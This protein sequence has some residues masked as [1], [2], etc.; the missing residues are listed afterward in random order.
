LQ[1]FFIAQET[2]V[3]TLSSSANY[4]DNWGYLWTG[5]AAYS[6]WDDSNTVFQASR[7]GDGYYGGATTLVMNAGDAVPITWL[8]SN[9][10]GTAQSYFAI[11]APDGSYT[12]DSTGYFVQACSSGTFA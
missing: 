9:G 4:I 3:Y 11:S 8:W 6:A 5:D 2:G 7:T 10:G 12:T 1:G